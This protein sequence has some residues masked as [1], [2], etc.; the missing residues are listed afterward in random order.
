MNQSNVTPAPTPR[1]GFR[2]SHRAVIPEAALTFREQKVLAALRSSTEPQSVQD[3]AR[4][5][6]PG[7]RAKPGKYETTTADGTK[8]RHA[9]A[10]AYRA[11]LNQLRRLIAGSFAQKTARGTYAALTDQQPATTITTTQPAAPAAGAPKETVKMIIRR[12]LAHAVLSQLARIAHISTMPVLSHVK[13]ISDGN[14]LTL[15]A[16]DLTTHI[17]A[18]IPSSGR[19]TGC[20]PAAALAA[21]V[22]PEDAKDKQAIVELLPE[23][24]DK[25]TVAVEAAMTTLCALPASDFPVRPGDKAAAWKNDGSW[26]TSQLA[27]A[28]EWVTRAAG[29]DETRRHL[30]GVLFAKGELVAVDGHRLH[31]VRIPG[32]ARTALLPGTSITALARLL[33]KSGEVTATRA[34]EFVRFAFATGDV[35]WEVETKIDTES[36]FPPYEQVIPQH[37]NFTTDVDRELLLRAVARMKPKGK[38]H[39]GVRV[40]VNGAIKIERDD[41]DGIAST[42]VQVLRSSH[43][44]PDSTIGVNGDY[45]IDAL[46]SG[47]DMVTARFGGELDPIR[48]DIGSDRTAVV[49]PMRQ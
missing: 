44:G 29:T 43:R 31:R 21:F 48:F 18:T 5:C 2:H 12:G 37:S 20:L 28:L 11:V 38:R 27:G 10:A 39:G 3:L 4:T 25:I 26:S 19:F 42:I 32:M 46:S 49:M 16:T 23:E 22:K 36:Q 7:F 30:C 6:F 17:T 35:K 33:P 24:G 14:I 15:E 47:G 34:G 13:L 40:V 1:G 9:T 8:V 41:G 45:L